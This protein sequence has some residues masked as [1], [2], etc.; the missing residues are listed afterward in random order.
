MRL[1]ATQQILLTIISMKMPLIISERES[2]LQIPVT[3][4]YLIMEFGTPQKNTLQERKA[5]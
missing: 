5:I 3:S 2:D 4:I 1:V